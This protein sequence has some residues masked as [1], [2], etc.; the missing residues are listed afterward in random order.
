M[1]YCEITGYAAQFWLRQ[2]NRKAQELAIAA[3]D[4]LLR[5]QAS[6]EGEQLGGALPYGLTRPEGE[7][8]PAYFSFDAGVCAAALADLALHTG[9]VRF[10]EGAQRA[11]AFLLRMQAEDGSFT[12]M[13]TTQPDHPGQ[14]PIEE[15]F[16]DRCTLHGKNAIAMLKLWH[17]TGQ[18][19]WGDAARRALD[20]VCGLQG[21]RGEF[22]QRADALASMTHTHCYATEGL[23]YAGLILGEG[24][25]L[26]A[27]VR[28]AEW[29]RAAQR[30]DGALYRDYRTD[31]GGLPRRG[32]GSPLYVGPVAQAARIWW[33]AAQVTP[34]RLWAEAAA[35]AL[36]FLA[37]VQ[38]A[39]VDPWVAGAFPQSARQIGPWLH[40][41]RVYSAWEAMF[42]YEAARLW[43][44]AEDEPAWSIF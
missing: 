29:L 2:S 23:L 32:R 24:C 40:P 16:G 12:A 35:R 42:A 5:V 43:A 34:G 13:R 14:P 10:A 38:A 39:A 11:G 20:W 37:R 19:H 30:R 28:G 25:Y 7:A 36:E 41:H 1:L 26:T 17:L 21:S 4:C 15:W 3:A 8:I 44:T 31:S 9:A 18:A 6:T 22:P 33:V 27:G